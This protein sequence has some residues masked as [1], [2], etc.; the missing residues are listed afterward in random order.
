MGDAVL[1]CN[2]GGGGGGRKGASIAYIEMCS[3]IVLLLYELILIVADLSI[4][5]CMK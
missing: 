2:G 5:L 1:G 4:G 3:R